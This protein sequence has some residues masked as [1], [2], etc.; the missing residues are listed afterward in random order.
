MPNSSASG[1]LGP[2]DVFDFIE[3][4]LSAKHLR[5]ME[6]H[7]DQ[8]ADCVETMAMVLRSERPASPEEQGLLARIPE[9]G[10]EEAARRL[11]PAITSSLPR[12]E[13]SAEWKPVA[14]AALIL[15]ALGGGAWMVYHRYWL[16]AESRRIASETMAAIVE[17]RQ[18][19]GRIPLR[20]IA[21]LERASVTRSG[22]DTAEPEEEALIA[23]LR[24]AVGR[25]PVPE[26]VLALALLDLDDDR[27][28]EAEP[29]FQKVL[30]QDP[31]SADALNGLAVVYF[32]RAQQNPKDAY[33]LLQR[34]L[35]FL[36][37]AQAAA[38]EDLRILYNF[39]KFYE[40]MDMKPAAI[41]A[42]SRYIEKDR[43]S[44]WAEEAAYQLSQLLPR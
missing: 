10:P 24:D 31:A 20:Y 11:A 6:E 28:D 21:E 33:P 22:F 4:R 30:A 35:A 29:L 3:R 36:R 9:P 15:L 37:Q 7:L 32:A 42:W 44:Q 8:C 43:S 12:P 25:A 19:T 2:E 27:L 13:A 14:A 40:A 1:H 17:S 39:G 41:Q 18:A 16:P 26:A 23:N 34:G 5:S 38:P